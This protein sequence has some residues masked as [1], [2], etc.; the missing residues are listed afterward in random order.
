M[1][2]RRLVIVGAVV[3]GGLLGVTG[4]AAAHV[5]TEPGSAPQGSVANVSFQVPDE[6]ATATTTKVEVAF[7]TD[8]PIASV[9]V[10]AL[11]GWHVTVAHVRLAKPL[12]SDDG[13]VT[14]AVSRITWSGGS[15]APGTFEDFTVSLGPLPTDTDRLVFKAIQTYSNGDVVRWIDT[16]MP[17]G[18]EPDHPAP[19]LRLVPAF[20]AVPAGVVRSTAT[21]ITSPAS[22]SGEPLGVIGIVVGLL[23]CV[24]AAVALR[25]ARRAS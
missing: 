12:D 24:L 4:T 25:R 9:D 3:A 8:H 23:G 15:I 22:T 13:P 11:P 17:G 14:Q 19:T 21:G 5:V 2:M 7:P 20:P 6:Q 10:K 16:S 18:A 1:T